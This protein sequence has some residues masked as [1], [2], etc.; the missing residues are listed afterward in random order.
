MKNYEIVE[1]AAR[2]YNESTKWL[3]QE[4]KALQNN[5]FDWA[6]TCREIRIRED[7]KVYGILEAYELIT[8]IKLNVNILADV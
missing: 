4:I 7:A 6:E 3:E 2:H 5:E 8:G 1:A